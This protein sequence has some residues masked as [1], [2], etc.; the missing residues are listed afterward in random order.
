[1]PERQRIQARHRLV[2]Q[3]QLRAFAYRDGER[4]LSSRVIQPYHYQPADRFWAFQ[5][6]ETAILVGLAGLLL[7]FTVYW[8]TRR[9]S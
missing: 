4:D 6:I 8:V 1:V 9:L 7:A 2:L 3:E 5:T